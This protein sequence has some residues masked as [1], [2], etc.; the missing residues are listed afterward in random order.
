MLRPG[1]HEY[2]V[3]LLQLDLNPVAALPD[4]CL[5]LDARLRVQPPE[6]RLSPKSW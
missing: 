1:R 4:E 5:A 2:R 3:T 6:P